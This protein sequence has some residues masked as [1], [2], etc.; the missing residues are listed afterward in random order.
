MGVTVLRYYVTVFT[1]NMKEAGTQA[2]VHATLFGSRGDSGRR[3]LLNSLSHNLRFLPGQVDVF[4][5][6]AVHLGTLE[7][8]QFE[9]DGKNKGLLNLIDL[10]DTMCY[11]YMKCNSLKCTCIYTH[12]R[13]HTL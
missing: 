2:R 13:T 9:H 10:T 12:T 1:G 11:L 7:K 3:P 8:I 5:L 4:V 6:E